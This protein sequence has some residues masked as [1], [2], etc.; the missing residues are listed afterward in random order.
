[1]SDPERSSGSVIGLISD[2][3]LFRVGSIIRC[4]PL[5]SEGWMR[6]TP[7]VHE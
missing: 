1:M 5:F 4:F 2:A 6:S 7:A 3:W